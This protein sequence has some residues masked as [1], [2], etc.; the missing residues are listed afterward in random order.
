MFRPYT[1]TSL[2]AWTAGSLVGNRAYYS[3][4]EKQYLQGLASKLVDEY[5]Q[6]RNYG[7]DLAV[8][9]WLD[10][11]KRNRSLTRE[12]L[13]IRIIFLE[14]QARNLS[15]E[16]K[17]LYVAT[18]LNIFFVSPQED[19]LYA[20]FDFIG[21]EILYPIWAAFYRQ[22]RD[23]S[24]SHADAIHQSVCGLKLSVGRSGQFCKFLAGIFPHGLPSSPQSVPPSV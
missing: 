24:L 12:E 20:D 1:P 6:Y 4:K 19:A 5:E 11:K 18:R 15:D 14:F 8:T 21:D 10:E 22:L 3:T 13:A 17:A 2:V 23:D 9:D 16:E 7:G